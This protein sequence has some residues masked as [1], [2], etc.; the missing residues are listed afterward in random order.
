MSVGTETTQD[1]MAAAQVFA[2]GVAETAEYKEYEAAA[3]AFRNNEEAR[4]LLR[5]FQ[6]AT[7]QRRSMLGGGGNGD[8]QDLDTLRA[9]VTANPVLAR[10][11][12]SQE[13]LVNKL[14]EI[15]Q[16]MTE[17]LGFDFAELTKPAG[18]CC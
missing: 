18:G 14:K 13:E 4:T 11:F 1:I 16:Y 10:Y 3:A 17:R 6:T 2:A 8:E 9:E 7:A 5:R 15:D 12:A